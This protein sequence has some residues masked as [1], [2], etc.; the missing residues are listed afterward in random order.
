MN[1][2]KDKGKVALID[3]LKINKY[4]DVVVD[5]TGNEQV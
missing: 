5:C 3:E 2:V 4:F 1:L